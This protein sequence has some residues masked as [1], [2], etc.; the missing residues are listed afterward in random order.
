MNS[1]SEPSSQPAVIVCSGVT[2]SHAVRI[3]PE[4]DLVPSLLNAAQ[5]A[6]EHSQ[7]KSAFVMTAVGS[8]TEVTLRMA[9]TDNNNNDNSDTPVPADSNNSSSNNDDKKRKAN[10]EQPSLAEATSLRIRTYHRHFEIVSLVGTFS[11]DTQGKVS[12]KHL[13]MSVS[14]SEGQVIGGHLISGRVY[15]TLELV[16]GTIQGVAFQREVVL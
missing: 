10:S 14:D 6:M 3:L 8:L 12:L 15:T 4:A 9:A 13:H 16:L 5:Q 2:Q 11:A 7:A 1:S